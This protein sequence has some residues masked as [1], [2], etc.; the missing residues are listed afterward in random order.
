D[1]DAALRV[2]HLHRASGDAP[3]AARA[4]LQAA[5]LAAPEERP[6][7][8]LEAADLW[9]KANEHGEAL[10]VIER[11]AAE[12]PDMLAPSELAERFGRLGAFSRALDVGFAPAMAAGDL[13]DA[14][15]MAA[16]AGDEART[17]EALW[18]LAALPDADAAH[19]SALADGLR[20]ERDA[21]GLLELAGLSV[22]RD[23]AFAVALRDEVLRSARSPV[24]QRLRAL[25]ELASDPGFAPRLTLLL[26]HLGELP[27]VL[28]EAVLQRVRA[29]PVDARE[30]AL[31][32]A[33]EGWPARRQGLLRERH[34]LE[35]ELGRFDAAARTLARLIAGEDDA[36]A[37]AGLHLEQGELLLSPLDRPEEARAA[38][39][40]AL[41]DDGAMTRALRNLLALVDE[42]REPAVFVSLA[43]RLTV[44]EG[45]EAAMP[46]RERLADAYEALG[47]V[48]D[49]AAQLEA[50]PE[51]E[52]RLARRAR[53]AEQRGRTGEALQLRERLT[54]EPAVL[55]SILR[56]YLDAQLVA[57]AARLA[58]R[59]FDAGR[60]S[61]EV[62]RLS[63]ERLSPVPEGAPLAARLWPTLLRAQP[64]DMDGWTLFAEALRGLG[65][66]EAAE[67][68][69]GIGA[70]LASSTATTAAVSVVPLPVPGGFAHPLPEGA[71]R[72]SDERF[73]RLFAALRPLLASLGAG[74]LGVSVD[75]TGG[76]EAYLS[77]P[78]ELVLGAGALACFGPVELGYLCA[79][80]LALGEAGVKLSRPGA[81]PELDAA[82]V[83]AFAAVPASL[84]AGRVLARLDDE[85]RGS[86]PSRVDVGAVLARGG[87]FQAVALSVLGRG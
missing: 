65:Q 27:E 13:T 79:L 31:A 66:A 39:E 82:A 59:L 83:A 29:L 51:T 41:E 5:R 17:R 9:E 46:H 49:A 75:P 37:R 76:V 53:L 32:M 34:T 26:P 18:A 23:A 58:E 16:Q 8:L 56:G 6:P 33:A 44:E 52:E 74:G 81:V 72:V 69:D 54:D 62:L 14:L 68:A 42:A 2:A 67:R 86:D 84:A 70:A 87:A 3:R 22:A 36:R 63:A 28:S 80:A 61:P 38:F 24:L 50:L 11:I 78:G 25:E 71:L 57:P 77:S 7:L 35:V 85:V 40:R 15:A 10:E 73:P 19:A 4:L 30:E 64:L 55:E 12:A 48:A 47:Q 60:L 20:E 45:P 43:E 1:V 21:E